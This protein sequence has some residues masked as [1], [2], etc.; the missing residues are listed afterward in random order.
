MN[1]KPLSDSQVRERGIRCWQKADK[2][3]S[4]SA[5]RDYFVREGM[6]CQLELERRQSLRKV[7]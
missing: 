1:L 5:A 2:V 3:Y 6:A 7:I 4:E